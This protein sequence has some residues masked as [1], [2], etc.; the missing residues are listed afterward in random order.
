[1]TGVNAQWP[2]LGTI[3]NLQNSIDSRKALLTA[4]K[5]AFDAAQPTLLAGLS[6]AQKDLEVAYDNLKQQAVVLN[7]GSASDAEIQLVNTSIADLQ[8]RM[9][10]VALAKQTMQLASETL[11]WAISESSAMETS[12]SSLDS[13]SDKYKSFQTGQAT[14]VQWFHYMTQLKAQLEAYNADK[15]HNKNPLVTSF[16]AGCDYTFATTKRAA[17][18]LTQVDNLPDKSATPPADIISLTMECASPFAVSAGV[19][20]STIPNNQFAIQPVA[21]SPGSTTTVNE[22]VQTSNSNFHPAPIG[23]VSA[24]LCEPN[25]TVSIHLSLGI[26]GNFN[27]QA[28]GGSSASFLIGPSIALFRTMYFTPGWYIGTKASLGSGFH[29][30]DPVPPNITTPPVNSSYTS[31]FGLAITFTKP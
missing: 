6:V 4:K 31:G 25:E 12:L 22:F 3:V 8:E 26:A 24:R 19:V 7:A 28:N 15:T 17:I 10:E 18:K 9:T 20:F 29:V 30:G 1:M 5:S 16:S 21:T 2:D 14:L 27:S 23:M 13:S 11:T